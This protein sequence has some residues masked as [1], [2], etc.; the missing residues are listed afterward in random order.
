MTY[1]PYPDYQFYVDWNPTVTTTNV[2][3]YERPA[4]DVQES[5]TAWMR[6]WIR[7]PLNGDTTPIYGQLGPLYDCGDYI[8]GIHPDGTL[9]TVLKKGE[10]EETVE[11]PDELVK[12]LE[13]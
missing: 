6:E 12:L 1:T 2:Y 3:T 7:F 9:Y 8:A 5:D 4:R 11:P 13:K 10:E